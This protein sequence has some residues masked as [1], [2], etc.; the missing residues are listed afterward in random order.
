MD[1]K[2]YFV[3]L[4]SCIHYRTDEEYRGRIRQIFRFDPAKIFTYDEKMTD[5]SELDPNTQDELL[6][7]TNAISG[8]MDKMYEDTSKE[9]FFQDLYL[10]AAGQMFSTDPKIGQ[11]VLCSYDTFHLY[12]AC[13]WFFY[14]D[15]ISGLLSCAEYKK[16]KTHF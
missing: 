3:T 7:D 4:P 1:F 5:F 11:A 8:S 14:V 10:Q 16:L 15:G 9:P 13:V 12:Y 6:F 2:S